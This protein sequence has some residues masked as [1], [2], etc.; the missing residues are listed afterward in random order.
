MNSRDA[1]WKEWVLVPLP[2]LFFRL[3]YTARASEA[4]SPPRRVPWLCHLRLLSDEFRGKWIQS[5][6]CAAAGRSCLLTVT[7]LLQ[8]S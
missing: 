6:H 4:C 8:A 1:L 7:Y 5:L 2:L 3:S